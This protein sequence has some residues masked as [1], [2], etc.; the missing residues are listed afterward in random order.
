MRDEKWIKSYRK[1]K[2]KT[3]ARKRKEFILAI[4]IQFGLMAVIFAV[5]MVLIKL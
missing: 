4:S 1:Q 3:I 5:C 2:A